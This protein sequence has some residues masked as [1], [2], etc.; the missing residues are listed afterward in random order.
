LPQ[1]NKKE[2]PHHPDY[3]KLINKWNLYLYAYEG[4]QEYIDWGG[5]NV[6][7][8]HPRENIGDYNFR[9][10]RAIYESISQTVI[11]VYQSHIRR[12]GV[13]GRESTNKE[14]ETFK[15]DVDLEGHD[16]DFFLLERVFS[17][18]QVFGFSYVTVDFPANE[19]SEIQT[20]YERKERDVR[21]YLINYY[22][23][24]AINWKWN[25][26]QFDWIV[27]KEKLIT[28]NDDPLDIN[29]K[30]EEQELYKVWTKDY[31]ALLDGKLNLISG[32]PDEGQHQW[33]G[34]PVILFVNRESLLYNLPICRSALKTIA[35]IDR[36][37]FNLSSLLDEFLYRQ[38][39]LQL[40]L[41]KETLG[42]II[43]LGTARAFP[44]DEEALK[45]Y[46]LEPPTGAGEFIVKERNNLIDSAYRHAMVRG[47]AYM[48]EQS[49]A[50]SGVSKAYDLHDS[51]QNIAQK[52]QNM[53]DGENQIHKLLKPFH[54]EIKAEW[55]L[56]FDI[57]T[58]N[59]ELAEA[60]EI[61][62]A[63]LGS[64]TY[65]R[66]KAFDLIAR[67][68]KNATPEMLEKIRTE[69]E[70]VNPELDFNERMMLFE[71][72]LY[73]TV[74]MMRSIDTESTPEQLQAQFNENVKKLQEKEGIMP[75]PSLKELME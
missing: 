16:L 11:Y 33:G 53:E 14:Y 8:R 49:V 66:E 13:K 69:L 43:E 52:S 30:R 46:F 31:W 62:K 20:E 72:G 5:E 38:C 54:G 40:V 41:D 23:T 7:Y 32:G 42:Q 65:A 15:L 70:N 12:K 36:K 3:D 6:L 19:V 34:V 21:P 71:K 10:E 75:E 18:T 67:D 64:P 74:K 28:G 4:G 61:F 39:F 9:Q 50:E 17:S 68:F 51:N 1:T 37:I 48:T 25:K 29:S 56:E 24:E 57:K 2:Y 27:F 60:I 47:D 73:D 58:M 22:P 45:P 44:V 26:G 63:K 55:P 35:E 59:E